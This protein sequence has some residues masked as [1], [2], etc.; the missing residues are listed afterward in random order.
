M[1]FWVNVSRQQE[2]AEKVL[3]KKLYRKNRCWRLKTILKGSEYTNPWW[4]VLEL[5]YASHHP[6]SSSPC[7]GNVE[8]DEHCGVSRLLDSDQ[9]RSMQEITNI[10]RFAEF[11]IRDSNVNGESTHENIENNDKI[12]R[13]WLPIARST[14][15][16]F[17]SQEKN[18]FDTHNLGQDH[19]WIH[20]SS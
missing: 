12:K 3:K 19:V 11:S 13:F 18:L 20:W 16:R 1:F 15:Q 2:Q 10:S 7:A 9:R 6:S 14:I 17:T 4:S 8:L 5:K